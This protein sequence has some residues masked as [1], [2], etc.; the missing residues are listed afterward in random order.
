[1][2]NGILAYEIV[3]CAVSKLTAAVSRRLEGAAREDDAASEGG[4]GM[5]AGGPVHLLPVKN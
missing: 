5:K 3:V 1:M 4:G 2:K